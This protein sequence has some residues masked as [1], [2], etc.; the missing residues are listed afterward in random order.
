MKGPYHNQGT[1]KSAFPDPWPWEY[2]RVVRGRWY[3]VTKPFVDADGDTHAV[4]EEWQFIKSSFLPYDEFY[5]L[6]VR[7]R[8][9]P[10]EWRI[11][12]RWRDDTP[13]ESEILEHFAD[14]VKPLEM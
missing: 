6:F 4:G 10:G 12:L 14:Y 1:A 11:K 5:I 2:G 13:S 7:L 8:D 9:D 3:R